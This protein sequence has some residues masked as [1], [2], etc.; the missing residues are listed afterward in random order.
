MRVM[1]GR[2]KKINDESEMIRRKRLAIEVENEE[3]RRIESKA[4]VKKKI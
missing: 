1:W 2:Y 4:I 3:I